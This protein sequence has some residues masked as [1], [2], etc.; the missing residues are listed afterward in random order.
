MIHFTILLEFEES[1]IG[2]VL[3]CRTK[4]YLATALNA[5]CHERKYQLLILRKGD[6]RLI[7]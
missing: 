6:E 7:E 2:I 5:H 3:E 4:L 1:D